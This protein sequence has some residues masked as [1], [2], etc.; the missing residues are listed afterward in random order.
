[1]T[2]FAVTAIACSTARASRHHWRASPWFLRSAL[3]IHRGE[4]GDFHYGPQAHRYRGSWNGYYG[5]WQ[6]TLGTWQR[7]DRL[8]GRHDD[9]Q[10]SPP[11]VQLWHVYAIWRDDGGSFREWPNTSR[12]CGLR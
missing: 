2:L 12:A 7:A 5:G 1:M 8:L 10:W 6:F 3:C 11:W 9:P 4:S